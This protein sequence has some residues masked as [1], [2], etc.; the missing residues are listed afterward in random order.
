MCLLGKAR[1]NSFDDLTDFFFTLTSIAA[2]LRS[3]YSS[4][5]L[6]LMPAILQDDCPIHWKTYCLTPRN[7]HSKARGLRLQ[8][9]LLY[10]VSDL[11][12]WLIQTITVTERC[13]P[14]LPE[15]CF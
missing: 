1:G 13:T 15:E 7:L 2:Y 6:A 10:T 3:V 12:L 9:I 11:L 4:A 8:K 14:L 5:F